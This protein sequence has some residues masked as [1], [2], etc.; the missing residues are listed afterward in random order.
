M[1]RRAASARCGYERKNTLTLISLK[2][3]G[4]AGR[5]GPGLLL[6]PLGS[7]CLRG[8]SACGRGQR[9]RRRTNKRRGHLRQHPRLR[10]PSPSRCV[11]SPATVV[12]PSQP[13]TSSTATSSTEKPIS[14]PSPPSSRADA[15]CPLIPSSSLRSSS[16]RRCRLQPSLRPLGPSVLSHTHAGSLPKVRG[17]FSLQQ[18]QWKT[19]IR[20]WLYPLSFVLPQVFKDIY[21]ILTD[22]V[23]AAFGA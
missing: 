18:H 12:S 8:R 23:Q 5:A 3:R 21:Y 4:K 17:R 22:S 14:P 13:P 1:C 15:P 7:C 2:I 11:A 9:K 10:Q 20:A 16:A 19:R 6:A